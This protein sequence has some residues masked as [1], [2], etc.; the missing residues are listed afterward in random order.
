MVISLLEVERELDLEQ[1]EVVFESFE[2][3][4]VLFGTGSV[5]GAAGFGLMEVVFG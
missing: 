5:V 2:V 4:F 3:A 1:V